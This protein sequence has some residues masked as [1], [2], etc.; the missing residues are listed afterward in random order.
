MSGTALSQGENMVKELES[1]DG[2]QNEVDRGRRGNEW[3]GDVHE[4]PEGPGAIDFRRF[5]ELLRHVLQA[6]KENN[7]RVAGVL[8]DHHRGDCPEGNGTVTEPSSR[9]RVQPG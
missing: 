7:H 9:Q 3:K 1:S 4:F 8:P 6:G 2:R 5:V